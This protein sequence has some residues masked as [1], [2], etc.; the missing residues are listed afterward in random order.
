MESLKSALTKKKIEF[1][2]LSKQ[3]ELIL[4][5]KQYLLSSFT[6]PLSS[7]NSSSLTNSSISGS[8]QMFPISPTLDKELNLT[9]LSPLTQ[10]SHIFIKNSTPLDTKNT[11]IIRPES[12]YAHG[13]YNAQIDY[14]INSHEFSSRINNLDHQKSSSSPNGTARIK[15]DLDVT[16]LNNQISTPTYSASPSSASSTSSTHVQSS[17][18]KIAH[19]C[20]QQTS[21]IVRSAS[22]S[23]MNILTNLGMGRSARS[24]N[25]SMCST[26]NDSTEMNECK[27]SKKNK[28]LNKSMISDGKLNFFFGLE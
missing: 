7:S 9:S 17:F 8:Q 3:Q 24:R 12:E 28:F 23:S 4:F 10:N 2:Q 27:K 21:R 15:C 19:K 5:K 18:N 22:S 16:S 20:M 11:S 13:D 1:E 14:R 25:S 26:L 6:S